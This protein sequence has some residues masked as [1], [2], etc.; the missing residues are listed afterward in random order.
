MFEVK[1]DCFAYDETKVSD[2][3]RCK[4]LNELYCRKENCR[5]YKKSKNNKKS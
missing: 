4:A 5:F 3:D 2:K 1:K